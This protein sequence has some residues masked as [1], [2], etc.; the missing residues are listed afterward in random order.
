MQWY[1]G[2]TLYDTLLIVGFAYVILVM[3]SSYLAPPPTVDDSVGGSAPKASNSVQ[4]RVG[5]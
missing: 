3:V 1:T 5:F 2:N 4:K